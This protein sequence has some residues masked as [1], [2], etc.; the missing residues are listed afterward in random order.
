MTIPAPWHKPKPRVR[1]YRGEYAGVWEKR[2]LK[3]GWPARAAKSMSL[4]L[5]GDERDPP[6]WVHLVLP[7]PTLTGDD[8]IAMRDEQYP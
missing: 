4:F 7:A 8:I 3:L 1:L 2:L 5:T 6:H